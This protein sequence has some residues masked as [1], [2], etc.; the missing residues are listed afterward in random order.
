[1]NV[2]EIITERILNEIEKGTLPWHKPWKSALGEDPANFI[3]KKAYRGINRFLL[4]TVPYAQPWYLTFK[5][6]SELGG[7]VRKGE[8]G[9]PV[10]FWKKS[11]YTTKDDATGEESTQAGMIL[12]YYTVFNVEQ[13][14][15]LTLPTIAQ[16]DNVTTFPPVPCAEAIVSGYKN[17]PTIIER[18]GDR[19]YYSPS[20]E[21]I[22]MPL[23]G[24]FNSQAEYY[25]TLFHEMTH[26]TGHKSRLKRNTLLEA[27][28][29]GD[30]EYS[31]E[32]LVAEM[33]AAFLCG[34]AHIDNEA[35]LKNS[36]AYINGWKKKLRHDSKI[37]V[38]AAAQAQKAAD[39]I[40]GRS[41]NAE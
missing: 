37:V 19:A 20:L 3:S 27:H 31:K 35:A 2:Y 12:R 39:H 8:H 4:S 7:T 25:S 40:L 29:F 14:D 6:A 22:T 15:G 5:Q 34:E 30:A 1:M 32:E 21:S 36:A 17:A 28:Y 10:V 11:A 41:F 16:P 9:I 33:G 26:S 24:Q 23:R 18:P 13:C 38:L